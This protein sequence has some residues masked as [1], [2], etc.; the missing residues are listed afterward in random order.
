M[1]V[2]HLLATI[3]SRELTEWQA[4]FRVRNELQKD[5]QDTAMLEAE[6]LRGAAEI[7]ERVR[8]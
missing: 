3:S 7:R 2:G 5:H 4:W 8:P 6:A 1:T